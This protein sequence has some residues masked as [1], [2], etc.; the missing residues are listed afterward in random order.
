V[1][2][3][4]GQTQKFSTGGIPVHWSVEGGPQNG[5]ID[6]AGNYRAPSQITEERTIRVVATAGDGRRAYASVRLVKPGSGPTILRVKPVTATPGSVVN[7]EVTVETR[8]PGFAGVQFVLEY[9][10]SVAT[11]AD[12]VPEESNRPFIGIVFPGDVLPGAT[13]SVNVGDAG[14]VRVAAAATQNTLRSGVILRFP[15]KIKEGAGLGSYPL[16]L[17]ELRLYDQNRQQIPAQGLHGNLTIVSPASAC[18]DVD[19]NG[20]IN[21]VDAQMALQ[22]IVGLITLTPAQKEAADTDNDGTVTTGDV[23]KILRIIVGMDA[24]CGPDIPIP[25]PVQ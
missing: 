21:V 13:A 14:F 4:V 2:L 24:G 11:L 22:S 9:P 6:S 16:H 3:G 12:M 18:G 1:T 10:T 19:G 17:T 25:I 15:L 20:S 23:V 8:A 5:T 7:V